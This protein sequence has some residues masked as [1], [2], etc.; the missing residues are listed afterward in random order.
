MKNWFSGEKAMT[1]PESVSARRR[2]IRVAFVIFIVL[3]ASALFCGGRAHTLLPDN[4]TIEINGKTYR[5]LSVVEVSIDSGKEKE[6]LKKDRIMLEVAGQLHTITVTFPGP[7]GK[8]KIIKKR[9][10]LKLGEV[11]YLLSIPAL[12]GDDEGWLMPYGKENP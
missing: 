2:R 5:E 3:L 7:D 1:D 10:R 11:M 6:L 9:F 8:E 12:I 4:K